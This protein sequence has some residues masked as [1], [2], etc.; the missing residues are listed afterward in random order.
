MAAA[1]SIKMMKYMSN[2]TPNDGL[3]DGLTVTSGSLTITNTDPVLASVSITYSGDMTSTSELT[4][5]YSAS[6][7]DGD[8]LTPSYVWTN[9]TDGSTFASTAST[10]Q[11][12]AAT[13]NP[14]DVI[15]CALTVTDD[16]NGSDTLTT[17]DTIV[18][19]GP[20][21]QS[22]ASISTAGSQVGDTWTCSA[23]GSDQGRW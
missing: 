4:C 5:G 17:T 12:T 13:A 3:E 9:V 2:V 23:V 16:S 7:T 15:E 1:I 22:A 14:G 6:D 11:L 19:T 20:S 18:N 8:S 10:L 21:F